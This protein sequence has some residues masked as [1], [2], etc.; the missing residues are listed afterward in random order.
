M[1]NRRNLNSPQVPRMSEVFP[2]AVIADK[3]VFLSGTP[4]LIPSTGKLAESFEEQ[5][6]QA[7]LNIKT[8]LEEVGSGLEKIVKTTVFMVSGNEFAILNKVY[9]EIFPANAPA[10]STPQ[11]MPFPGGIL[12]SVEC[13]ALL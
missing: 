12:I 4:G 7:F 3:F 5:T 2:Q 9:S 10:R 13:I 6:R 1:E 11:V 8:I